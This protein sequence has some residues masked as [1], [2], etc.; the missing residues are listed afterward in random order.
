[1]AAVTEDANEPPTIARIFQFDFLPLGFMSRLIVRLLHLM[2]TSYYWQNGVILTSLDSMSR[3]LVEFLPGKQQI[4][5][6]VRGSD[7]AR[8]LVV[9]CA[10]LESLV[11]GWFF[12]SNVKPKVYA[13]CVHCLNLGKVNPSL[14]ELQSCIE[15]VMT[16][17]KFVYCNGYIP[18]RVKDLVIDVALKDLEKIEPSDIVK[19]KELGK[20]GFGTVWQCQFKNTTVAVKELDVE[21]MSSGEIASKFQEF[22]MEAFYMSTLQH[23]NIVRLLGLCMSPFCLVTEFIAYGDL[24]HYFRRNNGYI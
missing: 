12:S 5:I 2:S 24:Y 11:E 18:V 16:Q 23:D 1:M 14:F 4:L 22:C 21:G 3:A 20:G 13:P 17:R 7:K 9:L 19:E 15:A 8:V 6:A 10:E